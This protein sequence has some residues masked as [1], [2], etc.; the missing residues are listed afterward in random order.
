MSLIPEDEYKR[1]ASINLAPVVDFLFLVIAVFATMAVTRTALYDTEVDLVK[2]KN[3]PGA[4][5]PAKQESQIVNIS[6][7]SDGKYKW[8]TETDEFFL[9]RPEGIQKEIYRQQ[10]LGILPMEKSLTKV[11]LH[12]D[13]DARW[14][15]IAKAIFAIKETGCEINP[16]YEPSAN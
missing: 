5:S 8:I 11:L 7:T 10:K 6:V 13:K 1:Q 2:L 12:I 16:V 4:L 15:P 14:E 3:E 9:E